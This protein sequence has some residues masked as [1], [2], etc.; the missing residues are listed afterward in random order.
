MQVPIAQVGANVNP[1]PA[2]SAGGVTPF[3]D[4][5]SKQLQQAGAAV[6]GAGEAAMSIA[7]ML[8][9]EE[10][11]AGSKEAYTQFADYAT[12]TLH[13]PQ[14]GYLNKVGKSAVGYERARALGDLEKRARQIEE[15]LPN[16]VQKGKFRDA[17][18]RHMAAVK[19]SVYGHEASQRRVWNLGQ[20]RA[21]AKQAARDFINARVRGEVPQALVA[22][23]ELAAGP[24]AQGSPQGPRLVG[25]P[26]GQAGGRIVVPAG[27]QEPQPASLRGKTYAQAVAGA[28]RGPS[29]QMHWNTAVT[30]ANEVADLLGLP[31]DSAERRELVLETTT[32]MHAGVVEELLGADRNKEAKDYIANLDRSEVDS[33]AMLRMRREV[34]SATD[35]DRALE[36]SQRIMDE[37]AKGPT[38]NVAGVELDAHTWDEELRGSADY[39][40]IDTSTM[41]RRADALLQQQVDS[42]EIDAKEKRSA[43][44]HVREQHAMLVDEWNSVTKDKLLEAE[45]I[46]QS[47]PR[48]QV[49]SPSFPRTLRNEL[50]D[51]GQL[52]AARRLEGGRRVTVVEAYQQLQNDVDSGALVGMSNEQLFNRY[53]SVLGP[54]EW[55]EAQAKHA[56]ANKIER[57]L[58]KDDD[59]LSFETQIKR[60]AFDAK[61]ITLRSNSGAPVPATPAEFDRFERFQGE[62]QR[63]FQL[64]RA[65]GVKLTTAAKKQIV[66]D[67]VLDRVFIDEWGSDPERFYWDNLTPE[68]KANAYVTNPKTGVSTYIAKIDGRFVQQQKDEYRLGLIAPDEQDEAEKRY[69]E[70]KKAGDRAGIEM[71]FGAHGVATENPPVRLLSE[72]WEQMGEAWKQSQGNQ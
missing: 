30:Q 60:A 3:Q 12:E 10:D 61:I 37:L 32:A 43:M 46:L 20:T 41:L 9:D 71:L 64:E 18:A 7:S 48:M 14:T 67:V 38:T 1:T 51:R 54:N 22:G 15:Q 72:K 35:E 29:W 33:T 49:D 44:A 19:E 27:A 47:N 4:Q 17:A 45:K 65:A 59:V 24:E 55:N 63:R 42:G 40:R 2:M 56:A 11:T 58:A 25:Q 39:T 13:N 8:R 34:K 66:D 53:Y 26:S 69:R 62:I 5:S 36:L 23:G 16:D 6:Q 70:L 21:M 68:E 50:I 31:A 52:D 57:E 28:P